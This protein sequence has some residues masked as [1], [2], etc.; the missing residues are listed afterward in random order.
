M[1]T[2]STLV[3]HSNLMIPN[4]NKK[5]NNLQNLPHKD[6]SLH[7]QMMMYFNRILSVKMTMTFLKLHIL[8]SVLPLLPSK[9]LQ[10]SCKL[11]IK[12]RYFPLGYALS[13]ILMFIFVLVLSAID[14]WVVKNISG[15]LLVGLRWRSE[16][17]SKGK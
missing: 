3:S 7:H 11:I 14:F 9:Q 5:I 10:Y 8:L 1:E 2:I 17:D 16:V 13:T 15:R 4:L 12:K 6:I